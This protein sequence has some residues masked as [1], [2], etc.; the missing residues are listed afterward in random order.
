MRDYQWPTDIQTKI[1][2]FNKVNTSKAEILAHYDKLEDI[3]SCQFRMQSLL[4]PSARSG[5]AAILEYEKLGRGDMIFVPPYSSH[6]LW[7]TIGRYACPTGIYAPE[8]KAALVVHKYGYV[9][10]QISETSLVIEDS[11]DSLIIDSSAVMPLSGTYEVFSLPKIIGSWCGGVVITSNLNFVQWA[12]E[13]RHV[14]SPLAV[15]QSKLK[16][17]SLTEEL[18]PFSHYYFLEPLNRQLDLNGLLNISDCLSRIDEASWIIQERLLKVFSKFGGIFFEHNGRLPC[19]L[20]FSKR[21]YKV[22]NRSQW[23]VRY[24]NFLRNSLHN[25]YEPSWILP[26]H[27]GVD[28]DKFNALLNDLQEI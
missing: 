12:K 25:E 26:L 14:S 9:Q 2:A 3:L 8:M 24:F 21:S 17:L 18:D 10:Q 7:D 19:V 16:Y 23:L 28:S 13:D 1:R 15:H 20:P 6:C 4:F 22:N 11:V 27:F 5:I